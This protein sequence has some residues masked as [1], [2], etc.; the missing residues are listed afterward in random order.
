MIPEVDVVR[1]K[2]SEWAIHHPRI[3][4]IYLFGSYITRRS[5]HPSD[6]DIAIELENKQGDTAHGYWCSEGR[7]LEKQLTELLNYKVDLEWHDVEE[8]PIVKKGIE[9]GSIIVYEK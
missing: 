9:A 2:L 8:T 5:E 3:T 1:K 7:K 6:I 4:K